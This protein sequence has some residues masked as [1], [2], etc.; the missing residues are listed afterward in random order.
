MVHWPEGDYSPQSTAGHWVVAA[1][2]AAPPLLSQDS[3]GSP[4]PMLGLPWRAFRQGEGW[5]T[6]P[7]IM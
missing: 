3:R 7:Q 4:T 5:R 1:S 6:D 2:L